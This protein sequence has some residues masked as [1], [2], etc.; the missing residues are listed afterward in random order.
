MKK[1][2]SNSDIT[3]G[4][5]CKV[6]STHNYRVDNSYKKPSIDLETNAKSNKNLNKIKNQQNKNVTENLGFD[7]I[8]EK[9]KKTTVPFR[10]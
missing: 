7:N 3:T 8:N 10:E 2:P 4:N 9:K 1:F 5:S 6:G